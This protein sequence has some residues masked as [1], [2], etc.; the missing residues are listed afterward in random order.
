MSKAQLPPQG[1]E[2]D[3][4]KASAAFPEIPSP[5]LVKIEALRKGTKL[6]P[7]ARQAVQE[8]DILN[9]E[10]HI[11]SYSADGSE[12]HADQKVKIPARF[13]L[14]K[15]DTVIQFK[16][17]SASPFTIDIRDK[18]FFFADDRLGLTPL[19]EI[20]FIP[21]PR[22]LS[23][24]LPDGTPYSRVISQRG[25]DNFSF[26]MSDY[27]EFWK[28]GDQCKYCDIG[29]FLEEKRKGGLKVGRV[30]PRTAAGVIKEV[31]ENEP[32]FRHFTITG[33]AI[34]DPERETAVNC[35]YLNAINDAFAGLWYPAHMSI[36]AREEKYLKRIRETGLPAITM[37]MEVWDERLFNILCPGKAR[38]IGREEWIR[39]MIKGVDVF[40]RGKVLSNFVGG[41]E[42][43]PPWGF[44]DTRSAVKSTLQGLDFLMEH[45]VLPKLSIFYSEHGSALPGQASPPLEY[46]TELFM[47]S[48]ELLEKHKF[49][50]PGMDRCRACGFNDVMVDLWHY[51]RKEEPASRAAETA[52]REN[53]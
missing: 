32:V 44:K 49:P 16:Q 37:N 3:F 48:M 45:D 22:S 47:G 17:N 19:E 7:A 5:V 14:K 31:F 29:S 30:S 43:A 36:V 26:S 40:G 33:G 6:T 15:D 4:E 27:C 25:L 38:F 41:V 12:A 35:S 34:L 13:C 8:L 24:V 1:E 18:R 9:R 42:M 39:R 21:K 50:F 46:F 51:F 11:F 52:N 28:T 2:M 10:Y 20:Y 23:R 53:C